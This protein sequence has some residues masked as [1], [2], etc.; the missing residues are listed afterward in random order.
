M[1]AQP[2]ENIK[3]KVKGLEEDDLQRGHMICDI[4]NH[5]HVTQEFFAFVDILELPE[6]KQILS[7]GYSCVMHIH[8]SV[9]EI[10]I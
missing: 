7:Q 8:A 3:I 4:D 10:E 1:Y 2:G 6:H 9:H 5:C